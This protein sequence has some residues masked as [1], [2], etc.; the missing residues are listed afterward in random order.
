MNRFVLVSGGIL[1]VAAAAGLASDDTNPPPT[2]PPSTVAS[3]S[4][5]TPPSADA[6]VGL[7]LPLPPISN[8]LG[9]ARVERRVF[10][11][12]PNH[13]ADQ[14][15]ADYK[16]LKTW[17]KFKIAERDTFDW[18]NFP[19][20]AGFAL[21]TQIAQS[22]WHGRAM[23]KNFAEYYARSF[24]DGMIGNF[25]TEAMIPSLLHEDPRFFRSGVGSVWKRTYKAAR[26]VMVTRT[27]NGGSRFNF[28]EV[29][30]NSAVVAVTSAY[31]PDSRRLGP[32]AERVGLQIGNDVISNLM[33]EFWPDIKRKLQPMLHRHN[34]SN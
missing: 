7:R 5:A 27:E 17:E 14:E 32:A 23:G 28:S 22:G 19:L 6:D 31:Y 2:P 21:Q 26:Q 10:G 20:L 1:L 4:P 13:R 9:A 12:I 11:V 25:I 18:P 15:T 3:D 8:P 24:A 16:P 30:G 34:P 33:T 29:L